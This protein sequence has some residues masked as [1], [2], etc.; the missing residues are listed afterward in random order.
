[1]KEKSG[2]RTL[3]ASVLMSAPGPIVL[4]AALLAGR[5]ATQLAD[6]IRRTAELSAIVVSMVVFRILHRDGAADTA[7]RA[8]LE[9][10]A[11]F[12]VGAAMC[13]S[14]VV[15]LL[16]AL[17]STSS[18]QGNS[19]PGLIIAL[20]GVCANSW[21]FLRYRR[22]YRSTGETI[23]AVQRRLYGAKTLVDACVTTALAVVVIAPNAPVTRLV[24]VIGSII[25]AVYLVANGIVILR[26]KQMGGVA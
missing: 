11:N 18:T 2:E 15:M 8:R 23:L 1:M 10:I 17:L 3:L 25:V 19:V 13:L 12:G 20:L 22:L 24:D 5:S 4:G 14:G 21:F 6:F 7:R 26:G 9:W 16:I